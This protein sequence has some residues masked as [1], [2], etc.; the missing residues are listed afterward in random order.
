MTQPT[1][2]DRQRS[3]LRALQI[4]SVLAVLSVLFQ[5]LTAGEL[6]PDG[7]P[8]EVHAGGA[9]VLHVLSGLAAIAA[10]LAWRAAV[11]PTWVAVLGVVVFAAT[12]VQAATGGRESLWIH[13]PGAMVLTV[14]VVVLAVRAFIRS[15]DRV[16]ARV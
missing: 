8:E 9:I 4:T 12:F 14:G 15:G 16:P 3:L 10:V 6:F 1:T 5:F 2:P 7:G 13:V 11:V